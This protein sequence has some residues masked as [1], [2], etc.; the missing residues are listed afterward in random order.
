MEDRDRKA[1]AFHSVVGWL[2]CGRRTSERVHELTFEACVTRL[3]VSGQMRR[4]LL[5]HPAV[6]VRI[7][8]RGIRGETLSLRIWAAET[9]FPASMHAV[10]RRS[11]TVDVDDRL[12]ESLRGFLRQV[13]TDAAADDPVRILAR[14]LLAVGVGVR[15][16]RTI[17]ITFKRDGG[18]GDDRAFGKPTFQVIVFCF[19]FSQASRQR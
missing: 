7:A 18:Y 6:A 12:G 5:G 16:W 9:A 11:E 2:L 8:E 13:V 10:R 1:Q 15:V 4:D 19:A 14:K 3:D 17:G